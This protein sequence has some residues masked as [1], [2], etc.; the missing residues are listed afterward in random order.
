MVFLCVIERYITYERKSLSTSEYMKFNPD[1]WSNSDI[2]LSSVEIDEAGVIENNEDTI[3]VD[4]ANEYIGGGC[5]GPGCV[6]EEILF[7]IF[8]EL[9]FSV[10]IFTPMKDNEAIVMKGAKRFSNYSGYAWSLKYAGKVQDDRI[11]RTFTA[12]DAQYLGNTEDQYSQ[13]FPPLITRELNK[14]MI[15]FQGDTDEVSEEKMPISTGN[16]GCGA[17]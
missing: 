5:M 10:M 4:F 3:M 13:F 2:S 17:F 11:D 6:Q 15:G 14:A 8:P 12:I 16:W 7:L 1:F 9:L